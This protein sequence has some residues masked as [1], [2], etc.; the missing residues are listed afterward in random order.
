MLRKLRIQNFK[1]WQD[2]AINF[3]CVVNR[4]SVIVL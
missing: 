2:T 3:S 1:L 4:A